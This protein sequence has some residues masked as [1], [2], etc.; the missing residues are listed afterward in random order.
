MSEMK[1]K[2][3]SEKRELVT[4]QESAMA[5]IASLQTQLASLVK[6]SEAEVEQ[7]AE[8]LA[9]V[10]KLNR[11]LKKRMS[12]LARKLAATTNLQTETELRL[13]DVCFAVSLAS[14]TLLVNSN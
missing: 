7:K 11:K 10:E 8:A 12:A 9:E 6:D 4:S 14:S 1:E 2:H 5:E 13:E 3:S